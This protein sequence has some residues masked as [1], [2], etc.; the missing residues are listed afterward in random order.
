MYS[1]YQSELQQHFENFP[2]FD[3]TKDEVT[4]NK[5]EVFEPMTIYLR[6]HF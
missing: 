6:F 2:D 4:G 5:V 3:T 1:Y